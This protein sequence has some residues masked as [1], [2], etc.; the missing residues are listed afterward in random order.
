MTEATR[1]R[2]LAEAERFPAFPGAAERMI[3]LLNVP[4]TSA[5]DAVRVLAERPAWSAALIR[6]A[7]SAYF[8]DGRSVAGVKEAV[9]L[10][11]WRSACRLIMAAGVQRLMDRPLPGYGLEKGELWR[12]AVGVFIAS[13]GILKELRLP[14]MEETATA[15]VFHDIGKLVLDDF[16][17][18][19]IGRIEALTAGDVSFEA[20]ER[21]VLGADHAE[22][23]AAILKNRGFSPRVVRAVRYNHE[24]DAAGETDP[25]TDLVHAANVLCA[26]LGVGAGREEL[27]LAPSPAAARRIGLTTKQIEKAASQITHQIDEVAGLLKLTEH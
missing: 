12:H 24:P 11:G 3:A 21:I 23:G 25:L 13:D 26:T 15:A 27:M 6:M 4:G 16:V 14:E 9:D 8:G 22:T 10:L 18:E 20:A 2:I 19:E 1:R 17:A 7:N 5:A